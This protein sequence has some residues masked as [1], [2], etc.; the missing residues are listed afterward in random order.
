MRTEKHDT[1]FV[2]QMSFDDIY[3]N[4]LNFG[5]ESQGGH[6]IVIIGKPGVGKST[7]ISALM[8]S[9]SKLVPVTV[10][11]NGTEASTGFYR[12]RIP[13]LFVY[14]EYDETV[15]KN[16]AVRQKQ[17]R[18]TLENPWLMLIVDDCTEDPKVLNTPAVHDLFK[19]GRHYKMLFVLSLQYALD[20]KPG[21]RACIDIV[22]IFRETREDTRR[23]LYTNFASVIGSYATFCAAMDALTGNHTALVINN[24]VDSNSP[25]DCV[26][27]MR[28][29]DPADG[30]PFSMGCY[31]TR[32][33]SKRRL[34][35]EE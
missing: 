27:Y 8:K 19:N 11:L 31:E 15:I 29:D 21:I 18:R 25:G 7:F 2:R 24:T 5:K 32:K 28:V 22:I 30:D 23:K 35:P 17:A 9:K 16:V 13:E 6:K 26:F 33:H 3:P 4:P 14:D 10:A 34:K 12:D 20:V 1:M